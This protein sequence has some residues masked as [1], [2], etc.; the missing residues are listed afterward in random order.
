[1]ESEFVT[2]LGMHGRKECQTQLAPVR[3]TC[4]I[5]HMYRELQTICVGVGWIGKTE[6]GRIA[7]VYER[8]RS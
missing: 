1:M 6:E 3:I 5:I 8:E 7:S 4:S 2:G